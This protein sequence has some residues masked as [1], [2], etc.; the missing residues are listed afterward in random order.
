MREVEL[1]EHKKHLGHHTEQ[2][3]FSDFLHRKLTREW[4]LYEWKRQKPKP[5]K[6]NHQET[7]EKRIDSQGLS[8]DEWQ[9]TQNES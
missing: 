4:A 1:K 6:A 5:T 3:A 9:E 2:Y 7:S 8:F